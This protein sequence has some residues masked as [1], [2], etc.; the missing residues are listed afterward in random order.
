MCYLI[1]DGSNGKEYT[2]ARLIDN[3]LM[4]KLLEGRNDLYAEYYSEEQ[5]SNRMLAKHV[6]P[7]LMKAGAFAM[8]TRE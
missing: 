1:P 6:F 7:I 2:E 3:A 8:E 5:K 4:D